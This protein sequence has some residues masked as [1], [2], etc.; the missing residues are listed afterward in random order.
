MKRCK[1]KKALLV[2]VLIVAGI[3]LLM[4]GSTTVLA[5]KKVRLTCIPGPAGE[6][7]IE[8]AKAFMKK[9]P[10]VEIKVD[11]AG[12]AEEVYKPTFPQIAGSPDRPDMAWYWVD[13][14]QYQAIAEA[15]FLVSL[16]DLYEKEGWN[17]VLPQST[18]NKYTQ[19]D[20]HRYAVNVD[21][22]WYPQVYYNRKIF[23]ELG[24]LAPGTPY[25][26]Y[27]TLEEW[28]TLID[29]IRS[30]GCEPVTYGGREGWII[31][32]THDALLQRMVPEEL[33]QDL[34][35]NWRPGWKPKIRYTDKEWLEVDKM[36][37]EWYK[38]GVFAE[39]YLGRSYPEGRAL[40]VQEQAAM[41]QDGSWTVGILRKEAPELDFGWMLYPKIE[42]EIDPQFLL[43]AGNGVMILKGTKHLDICKDFLAFVMSKERQIALVE[44]P[45]AFIPSRIDIP[46]EVMKKGLDP[47]EFDMWQNLDKIGTATGWDD[48]VPADLAERSF[49]LF[50]EMLT[51]ARSPESVGRELERIAER[52][53][54]R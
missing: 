44:S 19:P 8:D 37:L 17:K 36:L 38:K 28:Y 52:H 42:E 7:L 34:F 30:G 18:L 27:S 31:G 9:Y 24:L 40:F 33:L 51:G 32:H 26:A 5:Q 41:Y 1:G 13:G 12:G 2:G 50:Q 14:R 39:G 49:I 53:R 3:L 21:I 10:D 4:T 46:L 16:N 35:N 11:I 29:K 54:R 20:G 45:I 6:R 25:A 48:P 15:G 22:V 47:V 43:Y 23:A